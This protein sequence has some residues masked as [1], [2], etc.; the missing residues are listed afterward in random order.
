VAET[1]QPYAYTADDPL[2][3]T[4]PLGLM[5]PSKSDLQWNAKHGCGTGRKKKCVG[6]AH[7]VI[8]VADNVRHAVATHRRG[9]EQ[10]GIDTAAVVGGAVCVAASGGG[11]LGVIAGLGAAAGT[12]DYAVSGRHI[13]PTGVLTS[14]TEGAVIGELGATCALACGAAAAAIDVTV[15]GGTGVSDYIGANSNPTVTGAIGAFVG[16]AANSA[17]YPLD[18]IF[19][20]GE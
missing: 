18:K 10:I 19:G 2:N 11:C 17:P 20:G 16:G 14:A 6:V 3:A 12:G 5:V 1:G 13:T 9:L 7:A 8:H 15:G 4:D